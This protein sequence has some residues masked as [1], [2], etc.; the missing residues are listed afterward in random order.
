MDC[1][2]G[3]KMELIV[4]DGG[5]VLESMSAYWCG[6]CGRMAGKSP[7]KIQWKEPKALFENK[8]QSF[9]KD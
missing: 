7:S 5:T 3:Y 9:R 8:E 1:K 6:N 2:C 4:K